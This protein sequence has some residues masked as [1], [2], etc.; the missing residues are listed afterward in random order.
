MRNLEIAPIFSQMGDL[1]EIEDAN[2]FRVRAYRRAALSLENL[3]NTIEEIA[4]RGELQEI[5]GI[6]ADL[7]D[8]DT[9]VLPAGTEVDIR[10]DGT[11][12]YPNDILGKLDLLVASVHSGWKQDRRTMT[13]RM[14]RAMR[15]PHTRVIGHPTGGLLGDRDGY[16]VDMDEV[17]K[18]AA[19]TRTCLEVNSHFHRLDLGDTLCRKAREMG[20]H[21]VVST[22]AHNSENLLN[23]PYGIAMAQRGWIERDQVLN[24]RPVEE[25]LEF[26]TSG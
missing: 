4:G 15:N 5:P 7:K 16:D 12:D 22:D 6:G 8:K 13:R 10:S 19:R 24:T 11:L 2:P 26:K 21:V 1:L 17:M 3:T 18:E 20:V 14:V 25:L 23:L 9:G